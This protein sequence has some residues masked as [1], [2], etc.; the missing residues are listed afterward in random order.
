MTVLSSLMSQAV[1]AAMLSSRLMTSPPVAS[2]IHRRVSPPCACDVWE[3]ISGD[4]GVLL[5][6]GTPAAAVKD[7]GSMQVAAE[8][9]FARVHYTAKL[10]DGTLLSDS[11]EAGE[12]L[13][14]R[15]GMQPSEGVPGWDLALPLLGVGEAVSLRCEPQYA[16]GE[17]GAAP[18]IPPNATVLFELELLSVRDLLGSNNTEDVDL[19]D[20][21]SSMMAQEEQ[22]KLA[23]KEAAEVEVIDDWEF[24]GKKARKSQGQNAPT[25]P[26]IANDNAIPYANGQAAPPAASNGAREGDSQPTA[27]QGGR[28][29]IPPKRQLEVQSAAGYSWRETDDEI[30]VRLPLPSATTTSADLAVSIES[31]A[32]SVSICGEVALSG[33]LCG[34]LLVDE[35]S[36][37]LERT[38]DADAG[39]LQL[40]LVK[41]ETTSREEPLWGYLLEADRVGA[42]DAEDIE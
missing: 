35:S 14:L 1:M 37:S 27:A 29:W 39:V 5:R 34:R 13:E 12:S 22:A 2:M 21:Y 36:W 6:R 25:S 3:D 17:A 28:G 30:E 19:A 26:L 23:A 11:R 4:G 16:F 38:D 41:H 42:R 31:R 18:H 10:E 8:R 7:D 20:R 32:L 33:E 40:D 9:T 24:A 15:V